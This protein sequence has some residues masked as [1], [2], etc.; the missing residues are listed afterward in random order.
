MFAVKSW[1]I[2]IIIRT[3]HPDPRKEERKER[4]RQTDGGWGEGVYCSFVGSALC[5]SVGHGLN[6]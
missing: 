4:G 2:L 1:I 5:C 6:V 3:V